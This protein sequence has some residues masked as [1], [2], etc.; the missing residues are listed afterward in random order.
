MQQLAYERSQ[1]TAY[2]PIQQRTQS[3]PCSGFVSFVINI[4]SYVFGAANGSQLSAINVNVR[5]FA[6]DQQVPLMGQD[7]SAEQAQ[8]ATSAA[9]GRSQPIQ[10]P[11]TRKKVKFIVNSV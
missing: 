1:Q 5:P 3:N 2:Q 10:A 9:I 4:P 6:Y 11:A 7:R 8:G